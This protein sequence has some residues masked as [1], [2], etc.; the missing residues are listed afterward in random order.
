MYK[1][2]TG[3]ILAAALVAGCAEETVPESAPLTS[4]AKPK[5]TRA[6]APKPTEPSRP[7]DPAVYARIAKM[8]DCDKLQEQFDLAERTS[9]REG[10]PQGATWSEIGIAYMT[11][12]DERMRKVDCY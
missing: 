10:G 4:A 12:A 9:Q 6:P 8:T 1:I 11:A 5:A 2:I 3:L 7:G